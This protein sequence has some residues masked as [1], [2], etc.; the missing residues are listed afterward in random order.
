MNRN[1]GTWGI[2]G[3]WATYEDYLASDIWKEKSNYLISL[4]GECELCGSTNFLCVHHKTYE[5]VGNE[6][7][8]DLLVVC[9][10]CHYKIHK[11]TLENTED[12]K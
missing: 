3:L 10:G 1:Y 5:H 2:A 6:P 12:K 9:F 7:R 4:V 11:K 8:K